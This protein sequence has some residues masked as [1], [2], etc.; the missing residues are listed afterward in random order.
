[1]S[2]G[3]AVKAARRFGA[4]A[5]LKSRQIQHFGPLSRT[6]SPDYHEGKV[7]SR[8]QQG[9]ESVAF[10][11]VINAFNAAGHHTR[12]RAMFR[13]GAA[14]RAIVLVLRSPAI[15]EVVRDA[16]SGE[17]RRLSSVLGI[18]KTKPIH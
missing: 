7:E 13:T 2:F 11:F 3:S 18:V 8:C 5:D 9:K 12:E 15:R 4:S 1:V 16:R 14:R 6:S 17:R 10:L